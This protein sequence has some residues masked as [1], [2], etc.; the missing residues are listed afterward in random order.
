MV[1]SPRFLVV[2]A[3]TQRHDP[4]P[5]RVPLGRGGLTPSV[6]WRTRAASEG[7]ARDLEQPRHAVAQPARPRVV[8]LAL[9]VAAVD[10]LAEDRR[11]PHGERLV[12]GEIRDV[13]L[14]LVGVALGQLL[15][16]GETGLRR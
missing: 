10:R 14:R 4:A 2:D 8:A 16:G 6:R 13:A 3:G 1:A 5:A 11:L 15:A 7:R 9:E 12:P